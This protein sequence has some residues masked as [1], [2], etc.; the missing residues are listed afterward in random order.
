MEVAFPPG[1]RASRPHAL[2]L[3]TAQFPCDMAPGHPA[4]GN[5][6]GSA[7]AES[8]RRCRSS[9]V[10]ERGKA[11]PVLCGRDARAP[12][13]GRHSV[14]SPQ[15]RRSIGLCVHSWFNSIDAWVF[16]SRMIRTAGAV[17]PRGARRMGRGTPPGARASRPHAL[18]LRTAQFPCDMAPGHPAA[19]N[20]LGSA[21]AESWRRCRSSR[22]GERG[23]AVPVLCG[24][25]ARAPGVGRHS[26]TSPQQ[27][28]SIGLCAHSWFVL[29]DNRCFTYG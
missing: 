2:P 26:V 22:V 17:P 1:A 27:R 11:V 15:E 10:G 19:G 14:T 16:H 7:E 25:D 3:G 23:E 5:G 13:V 9:R 29:I 8:W 20:G 21:E 18:P 12:G 4:G 24:R 28:R 6:L